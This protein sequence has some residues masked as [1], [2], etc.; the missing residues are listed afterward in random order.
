MHDVKFRRLVLAHWR[1][2]GRHDLPWRTK[3]TPY[4]ALVSELMLQQTQV[5]RVVPKFRAFL[6][7]FPSFR[8]LAA[9][10]PSAVLAAWQ[11]LGYNRRAL[12]LHQCA[13]AVVR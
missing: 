6:N 9:A 13:Q 1:R 8:R 10:K 5:P 11:G 2:H 12:M 4:R 7:V 3:V